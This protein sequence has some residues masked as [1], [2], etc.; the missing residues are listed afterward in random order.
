MTSR[1]IPLVAG[2]WNNIFGTSRM[3]RCTA[4]DVYFPNAEGYLC[5]R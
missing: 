2:N 3:L 1:R 5:L 4:L